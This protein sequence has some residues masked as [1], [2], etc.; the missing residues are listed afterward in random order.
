MTAASG[1]TNGT[2]PDASAIPAQSP[3][4]PP[5]TAAA[6]AHAHATAATTVTAISTTVVAPV[7]AVAWPH[8]HPCVVWILAANHAVAEHAVV[9]RL[10]SAG[11]ATHWTAAVLVLGVTIG[12]LIALISR[13]F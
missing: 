5:T 13:W 11:V 1:R 6:N 12:I 3:S 4:S 7:V 2:G 9:A 10:A 8:A